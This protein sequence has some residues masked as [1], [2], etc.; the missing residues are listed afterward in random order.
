MLEKIKSYELETF[1]INSGYSF[2]I[3]REKDDNNNEYKLTYN[4]KTINYDTYMVIFIKDQ[5]NN[6]HLKFRY[7]SSIDY[8]RGLLSAIKV[9]HISK[10]RIE[11]VRGENLYLPI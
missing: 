9:Q 10:D 11:I 3:E 2:Y 8:E 6:Y 4:I 5:N 7:S 1:L